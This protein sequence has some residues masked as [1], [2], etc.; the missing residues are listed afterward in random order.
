MDYDNFEQMVLGANLN[1]V[2]SKEI[3]DLIGTNNDRSMISYVVVF[4]MDF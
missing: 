3:G 1:V 2:K 4:L